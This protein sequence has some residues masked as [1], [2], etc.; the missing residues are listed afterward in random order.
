MWPTDLI[1]IKTDLKE[2]ITDQLEAEGAI[3]SQIERNNEYEMGFSRVQV[4]KIKDY[5]VY[6]CLSI[7]IKIQR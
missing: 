4:I 3:S 2:V 5:S 7:L 6:G 1:L